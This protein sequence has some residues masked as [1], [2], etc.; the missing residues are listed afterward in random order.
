MLLIIGDFIIA[1]I[2]TMIALALWSEFDYLTLSEEFVRARAGWFVL[3]PL[4]WLVLMINMYDHRSSASWA[5]TLRGVLVAAGMGTILYLSVYFFR[6]EAGSLPRRGPLYF[7][8]IVVALTLT[9]RWIYIKVFTSIQF[10][11][12][13]LVVGAGTSGTA[14]VELLQGLE[15]SPFYIVGLVDDDAEKHGKEFH[16]IEVLG[17]SSQLEE[18]IIEEEVS[19]IIVAILGPMN[20]EMFQAL[21]DAQ[22]R[23]VEIIRMPVLYE[24]LLGRVP[25]HHLESDWLLRSFVDEVRVSSVYL[26]AKRLFDFFGALVGIFALLLV[27]PWV[28]ISILLESGRPIFFT[29]QRLG[30]RGKPYSLIKFRTMR[31]DAEPNGVAQWAHEGDPRTTKVGLLLRKLHV[32]EFPQFINVLL[33]NMSLVGPRPERPE[34]VEQLEKEI[35]F[36][37]ARLLAKPGI[38]G[39]AQVNY[40]KGGSIEGSAEKLEFD[41]YYIKHRS[42]LLDLWVM[43]RSVGQG[44]VFRGV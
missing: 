5:E 8:I 26:I 44:I 20:G 18:L 40:G 37:R 23:W 27:L 6:T 17:G 39:W 34:L 32:D 4:V 28:S 31:Q 19:D 11:R 15:S 13:V 3:L 43:F 36:Y 7:L 30:L 14:L 42:M 35:P 1:I 24:E 10:L 38:G 33:G 41:L 25:I 16:G 22:E 12:R 29:Q 9:W 21:L 2:S